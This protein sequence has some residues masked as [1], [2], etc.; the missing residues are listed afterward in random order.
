VLEEWMGGEILYPSLFPYKVGEI[1]V[2]SVFD[3]RDCHVLAI[4]DSPIATN[5]PYFEKIMNSTPTRIPQSLASLAAGYVERIH[6]AL[7]PGAY[8][9]HTEMR[10][11]PEGLMIVE[12]GVRIGGSS[13]YRSVL[14]STGNDFLEILI[15]LALGRSVAM[16]DEEPVPTITHYLCA[17]A[18]GKIR[19]FRGI[20]H[21][22]SFPHYL[23]F[24]LY[25]DVGA[26]VTRPPLNTR[27]CGYVVVRGP[28]YEEL[29]REILGMLQ[30][31]SIE[32]E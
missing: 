8:V 7:G 22:Q 29:E 9:L 18:A 13:L 2:E 30:S 25:D 15:S 24:Q 19:S 11:F 12:F 28:S 31:F 23:D 5:G 26:F 16:V 1:S 10:T 27:A 3:G 4:H 6:R 20:T 14:H 21:L 32:M 17:P